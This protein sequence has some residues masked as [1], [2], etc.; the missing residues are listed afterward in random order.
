MKITFKDAFCIVVIIPLV[1]IIC[2][3]FFVI[4]EVYQKIM[5]VWKNK[6]RGNK[7]S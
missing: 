3:T 6:F 7:K 4:A 5:S 2:M 1:A